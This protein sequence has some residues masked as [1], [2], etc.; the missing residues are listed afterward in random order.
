MRSKILLTLIV[1][2]LLALIGWLG[3]M[4]LTTYQ[5]FQPASHNKQYLEEIR[6]IDQTITALQSEQKM[7]ALYLG[8]SGK[9][10][11]TELQDIRKKSDQAL[12]KLSEKNTH[13]STTLTSIE[14][15]LKYIRSS[16]DALNSHYPD[17]VGKSFD[18]EIYTPLVSMVQHAGSKLSTA[19]L[20]DSVQA[21]VSL[22]KSR[23]AL[24]TEGAFLSYI[25]AGK[26]PLTRERMYYWEALLE[27][28]GA[29]QLNLISDQKLQAKIHTM[30]AKFSK[31][32]E[33]ESIRGK[34]LE[35]ATK[36]AYT[37][38]P[39]G[40]SAAFQA[41]ESRKRQASQMITGYIEESSGIMLQTARTHLIQYGVALLASLLVLLLILRATSKSTQERKVLEET[42]KELVSDLPK[43]QQEEL[44]DILK[45]GDRV[46]IYRFLTDTTR[47]AREAREQ[48]LAAREQAIKAEKAKDLFLANMS[49]EIR[50]P[51]NGILGFTQLLESTNLDDEQ[52]GF[53]DIIKGS[54]DNLLNIVNS[55]LDLSKI[56][57]EKMDLEAIPFSPIDIFAD[58]I[59]PLEAQNAEKKI[60]YTAFVDPKL[61]MLIGDPTRLRQIMTNLIGNAIKFTKSGGSIDI[62]IE[63]ADRNEKEVTVLFS[64]KDTGI[65]IS[66]DQK[67]KIFEAFSQA[68][69]S[70]TRQFGGTGLGLAITSDLIKHMGGKLDVESR[71]GEGSEFFFTLR[72]EIAGDD[73]KH[74]HDFEGLR[75]A[76]YH[77]LDINERAFDRGLVRY[78]EAISAQSEIIE[79]LSEDITQRYDILLI[80]YALASVR[81]NITSILSLDI[82]IVI[83][84][85]ISYKEE[86]DAFS[87]DKVSIIYRPLLY[88]K[89]LKAIGSIHGKAQAKPIYTKEENK[90]NSS[91]ENMH[92]LV[93]EDNQINQ[94]LIRTVL[95][96]LKLNVT[97]AENGQIAV[98]LRR[99]HEFDLILMDIQ[100]PILGGIDATKAILELEKQEG[101]NHIPIVALTANALQ[102]DREK[103]LAAGMDDYMS[104]PIKIE[105]IRHMINK[106]CSNQEKAEK[107][108][109]LLGSKEKDEQEEDVLTEITDTAKNTPAVLRDKK[110]TEQKSKGVVL[111]YFYSAMLQRLHTHIL[112]Q[113]GFEVEV[114][115]NEEAF[116]E[117]FDLLE[118]RYVLLNSKLI[119]DNSSILLDAIQENGSIPL[120]YGS[121]EKH[122]GNNTVERYTTIKELLS[123][124]KVL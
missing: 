110:A 31:N 20:N 1:L 42:L 44:D 90:K 120:L 24:G 75:L 2:P 85:Y 53:T 73:E 15:A 27:K 121:G 30:H 8:G 48:A 41:H 35:H 16:V 98:D 63:E 105:Q 124:L 29:P 103:Y 97:L 34:I 116:F 114:T 101:L 12:H 21:E 95:Q 69:I 56:R 104:K 14:N 9:N 26:K 36:G 62:A 18:T 65:G 55:I 78:L 25:S 93:V 67:E 115:D 49:H 122:L 76:Y 57:A 117:K 40:V 80:D 107:T 81:R 77:P 61:P 91:L 87:S 86:I 100:M 119:S 66:P 33:I 58:T 45:K 46:S 109:M 60:G 72:F 99:K 79:T 23:I 17:I 92:I 112:Q 5:D 28:E 7:S 123:K 43:T 10:F 54:S 96:N 52:Q 71:L 106:Y 50:T 89:L 59:E 19:S 39:T 82:K 84:G 118:P 37:T 6:S 51:L 108:S 22:L 13:N 111:L 68:D 11:E 83:I 38:K 102:G 3:Y 47:E 70:T 74:K 88:T 64:V 94:N 32:K 4:T 113:R